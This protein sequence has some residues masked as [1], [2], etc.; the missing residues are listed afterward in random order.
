MSGSPSHKIVQKVTDWLSVVSEVS[1][2]ADEVLISCDVTS[3]Y[4]N[5][6]V[7]KAIQEAI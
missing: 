4:T 2:D 5:V 3:L 1:L 7:K 6:P